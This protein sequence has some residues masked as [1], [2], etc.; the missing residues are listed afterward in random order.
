MSEL[1]NCI[2][3][4]SAKDIIKSIAKTA[5]GMPFYLQ[6]SGLGGFCPEYQIVYDAY[7]GTIPDATQAAA[8]NAM[9]CALVAAGVWAKLDT[10]HI[11]ANGDSPNCLLNWM[12]PGTL[13]ASLFNAP[14]F[15]S[16]EGI[17]GNGSTQYIDSN[18]NPT[19]SG[20][21]FIKDSASQIIYIR[22]DINT[23]TGHGIYLSLPADYQIVPRSDANVAYIR[24]NDLS[25][26]SVANANGTGMY[27]NTRTAAAVNKLYR[28]KV[29]IINGTSASVDLVNDNF[30]YLARNNDGV[31]F[32]HRADQIS[33]CAHGGGL[34][35]VDVDNFTDIFEIYMVF[36]G[37]GVIP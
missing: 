6:T 14:L 31:P 12:N 21:N 18:F 15:T 2:N 23:L 3:N 36:L 19:T 33:M 9:V 11:F 8:Q 22:T 35:Q 34:S 10:L 16:W 28:N 13:D 5:N 1:I 26:L 30:F 4:L 27:V 25:N 29:A 17:T 37:K 20:V 24:T 32:A 7:V